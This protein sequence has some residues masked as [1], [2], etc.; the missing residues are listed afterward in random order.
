M[1]FDSFYV[2]FGCFN[3]DGKID[4]KVIIGFSDPDDSIGRSD[5]GIPMTLE[6]DPNASLRELRE[7]AKA[8]AAKQLAE[9]LRLVEQHSADQLHDMSASAERMKNEESSAKLQKSIEEA[10]SKP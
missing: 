7:Q 6:A 8:F 10:L 2:K 4:A 5:I 9:A 1:K 3:D